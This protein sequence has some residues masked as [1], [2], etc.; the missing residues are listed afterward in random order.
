[1]DHI[2]VLNVGAFFSSCAFILFVYD[3]TRRDTFENVHKYLEHT[4]YSCRNPYLKKV[5]VGCK[6]DLSSGD[7][8]VPYEEGASYVQAQGLNMF[9]EVSATSMHNVEDMFANIFAQISE[10][11]VAR[12]WPKLDSRG[13]TLNAER[14]GVQI[15]PI[16]LVEQIAE[17]QRQKER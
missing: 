2:M 16:P 6:S 13:K 11:I 15:M 4:K 17:R 8:Q 1:M 5:L 14:Y 9:Y 3:I 10:F 12:P 7:R